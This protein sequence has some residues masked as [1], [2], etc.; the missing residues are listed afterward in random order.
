MDTHKKRQ[1]KTK[2]RTLRQSHYSLPLRRSLSPLP[3]SPFHQYPR[4][5]PAFNKK[6]KST[7]KQFKTQQKQQKQSQKKP[8]TTLQ[9]NLHPRLSLA[10]SFLQKLQNYQKTQSSPFLE[11]EEGFARRLKPWPL[12]LAEQF[13]FFFLFSFSSKSSKGLC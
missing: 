12:I 2:L 3:T 4:Q 6:N 13:R 1:K 5:T 11:Y 7:K 8:K 10:L 9:Q